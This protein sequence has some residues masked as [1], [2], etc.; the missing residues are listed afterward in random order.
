MTKTL[1]TKIRS[2]TIF[3]LILTFIVITLSFLPKAKAETKIVSLDP[4][5]GNVG[6]TVQLIANIST[7]NGLYKISFNGDELPGGNASGNNVTAS[8][9]IPHA[10]EGAHDVTIIDM[11]TGENDTATFTVLTSYLFEPAL[12]ES[13][14][15]LQQEANVTISA[16]MTG[17]KSNY[18]YPNI[19]V[20]TPSGNLTYEALVNITTNAVGDYYH[21]LTYP[22]DFSS[23]ANTNFTGDYKILLNETVVNSFFIGLTNSSEYHRGDLVNIKA[24]DY[25]L[26]QNVSVTISFGNESIDSIPLNVTDGIINKNWHVPQDALVGNYTLSITPVPESKQEAND[27]QIF[28]V[29][30]F[31]TEIL[32]LNLANQTVPNIFIKAYDQSADVYYNTTSNG[33]GSASFMFE[34]GIYNCEVFFKEV[35]V[36]TPPNVTITNK[37]EQMNFTCELANLN[38]K[39][40]DMQN[41]SIPQ[42]SISL[43]Y[44]YTTNLDE[45]ENRTET[46]FGETNMTGTLQ[47]HSLLPNIDYT[48]NASRYGDVFNQNNNTVS[49]LSAEA[50]VDIMILCPA[51]MLHVNVVDARN[52]SIVNVT[53][54]A[55]EFMGGLHYSKTTNINGTAILNC[56]FGRYFVRVYI[57][58]I[59]LNETTVDLF[60]NQ[61]ISITC[62]F[63]GLTVSVR[64]IDYL[65]QPI[66]N[67]NVTLQR[68]G[69]QPRSNITKSNGVATF[70]DF[71]GGS[72]QIAIY[73]SDKTQPCIETAS[74]VVSSATIEIKIGKYVLIAGILV[75]TSRL[76]T[77][78]VIAAAIILVI[79]VEVYRR[80]HVKLQKSSD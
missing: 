64:V 4:S 25:P 52:Q 41:V 67:A 49:N 79:L 12:P 65:G 2:L 28:E 17:G 55:Q 22:D 73:L 23:G 26:N 69:L 70:S 43:T 46:E 11:K 9:T 63:Y 7:P 37:G 74:S 71:I 68:E 47:L 29:P 50:Y 45:K 1:H 16:N 8:F 19:K 24:I 78:L 56:T 72:V 14:A 80:K 30:G 33:N 53:V 20:Q 5:S 13:P 62:N 38:I 76:A 32:T 75:E 57:G 66:P 18:T 3:L 40:M 51:K 21:N 39:V 77:A 6:T 48:I 34:R 35:R 60:Q 58:E 27:T 44:N 54:K 61:N 15:Q 59:Q 36:G 10:P 31:R 42:V